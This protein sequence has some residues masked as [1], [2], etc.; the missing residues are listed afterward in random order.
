MAEV[1]TGCLLEDW[2]NEVSEDEIIM[3][4]QVGPG[5][6]HN[7]VETA[8]WLLHAMQELARIFNFKAVSPLTKLIVRIRY[9]CREELL[10]L[11][12]LYGI[13]RVRARALFKRGFKSIPDL[14]KAS[15][16][17]LAGV[18]TIGKS[19]AKSIKEQVK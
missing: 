4:Y 7:K 8:E 6:I 9:G 17:T 3:K 19:I 16:S 5:D 11:V 1:K 15:V 14:R 10:N 12:K 18:P 2:I 13:G